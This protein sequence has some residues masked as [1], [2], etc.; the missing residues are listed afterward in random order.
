[1]KAGRRSILFHSTYL[2]ALICSLFPV[3]IVEAA[4]VGKSKSK[5]PETHGIT[6]E[7]NVTVDVP[8]S[9]SPSINIGSGT[10]IQN[11]ISGVPISDYDELKKKYETLSRNFSQEAENAYHQGTTAL[12]EGEQYFTEEKYLTAISF[13]KIASSLMNV[14]EPWIYLGTSYLVVGDNKSALK[15][16]EKAL[17]ID[18]QSWDAMVGLGLANKFML[19][20]D[21]AIANL[22][23]AFAL[24]PPNCF[25][26][27]ILGDMQLH[28]G[29]LADAEIE[30][31]IAKKTAPCP[32]A[33][34]GLSLVHIAKKV[35]TDPHGSSGSE[36]IINN[37]N[38]A[39]RLDPTNTEALS[40]LQLFGGPSIEEILPK[41]PDARRHFVN[42][43]KWFHLGQMEEA[44]SEYQKAETYDPMNSLIQLLMGDAYLYLRRL[45]EAVSR[46]KR[47]S[48]LDPK[49]YRA[50]RYLGDAFEKMGR[51]NDAKDAYETSL[52]INPQY[53]SAQ[54]DME[55]ILLRIKISES[56]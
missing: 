8:G 19:Q 51:L 3:N 32:Q 18:K 10:I 17:Q 50:W 25:L 36:E 12:K 56:K 45:D 15:A 2:V 9:G 16:F 24:K 41:N 52:K 21:D 27:S 14:K 42:A 20:L 4:E 46:Y 47:A 23:G 54:K 48:Q 1:M 40:L 53:L 6:I 49:S 22:K 13:L 30:F 28:T 55:R 38:R 33:F 26:R 31:T 39:L 7:G 11:F 35:I 37:I 29:K 34:V 43:E 5:S 44:L